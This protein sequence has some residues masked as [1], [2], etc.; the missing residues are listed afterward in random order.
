MK[1][2][3]LDESVRRG[4]ERGLMK[5]FFLSGMLLSLVATASCSVRSADASLVDAAKAS[6]K[7]AV[8]DDID[9]NRY[10]LSSVEEYGNG[11]TNLI[12][13]GSNDP[14]EL[15]IV[16][17]LKGQRYWQACYTHKNPEVAGA[18]FCYFM[19]RV[20]LKLL[21]AYRAK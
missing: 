2:R 7:Y 16:G 10:E 6:V 18:T 9:L 20:D 11:N 12:Q 3:P 19:R 1:E 15:Q 21:T 14:D 13:Y 8:Q 4:Y 17:K 5:P